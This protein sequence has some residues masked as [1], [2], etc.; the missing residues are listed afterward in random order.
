MD[1]AAL[2]RQRK[3][4]APAKSASLLQITFTHAPFEHSPLHVV[5]AAQAPVMSHCSVFA[6][7]SR[8]QRVVPGVQTAQLP[9]TQMGVPPL[10]V[11]AFH[12]L[13]VHLRAA[14]GD[15]HSAVPSLHTQ[16]PPLHAGVSPLQSVCGTQA[17]LAEHV[18]GVLLSAQSTAPCVHPH[19]PVAGRQTG[20]VPVHAAWLIHCPS[21]LHSCGAAPTQRVAPGAQATQPPFRHAGVEPLHTAPSFHLPPASQVWGVTSS[22]HCVSPSSQVPHCPVEA[23]QEGVAPPH[24]A[25]STQAVPSALHCCGLPELQ[26]RAS[27]T[28]TP[29]APSTQAGV[30]PAHGASSTQVPNSEHVCGRPVGEQRLESGAQATQVP[31][32]QAAAHAGALSHSPCAEHSSGTVVEPA[33]QREASGLH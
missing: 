16:L 28:H 14:V 29:H 2:A 6:E 18:S 12:T 7:P 21:L 5:P 1:A 19:C 8:A 20:V 3:L 22:P 23:T 24:A 11:V 31:P 27:G 26:R 32:K 30:S 17:P 25:P 4:N 15:V 9:F 10:H 33:L 13:F